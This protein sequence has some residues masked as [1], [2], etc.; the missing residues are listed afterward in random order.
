MIYCAGRIYINDSK[1]TYPIAIHMFNRIGIGIRPEDLCKLFEL[2]HQLETG[3]NRRHEDTGLGPAICKNLISL[4]GGEIR[5]ES[6]CG[7]GCTFTFT[8][9]MVPEGGPHSEHPDY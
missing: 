4:L 9:P 6:E 1:P 8:L 2:F 7:A 5:A 3:L